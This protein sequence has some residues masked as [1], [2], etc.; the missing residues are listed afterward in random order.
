MKS[1]VINMI[2][3]W[4]K[5]KQSESPTGIAPRTPGGEVMG[6]IPV[7][8]SDFS[9]STHTVFVGSGE[10]VHQSKANASQQISTTTNTLLGLIHDFEKKR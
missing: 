10:L 5:K 8:D 2:R 9:L 1:E 7:G 6:S 3:A 4:D